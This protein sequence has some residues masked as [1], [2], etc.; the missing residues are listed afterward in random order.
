MDLLSAED[1]STINTIMQSQNYMDIDEDV[2]S[3]K[4]AILTS[5]LHLL[6]YLEVQKAE[7]RR[8]FIST[9]DSDRIVWGLKEGLINELYGHLQRAADDSNPE[10]DWASLFY[11]REYLDSKPTSI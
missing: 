5:L 3:K 1:K 7:V 10:V 11:R 9:K 2:D 8:L 4:M 6:T